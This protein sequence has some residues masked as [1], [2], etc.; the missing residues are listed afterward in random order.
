[1]MI[2]AD[3]AID[4]VT[5]SLHHKSSLLCTNIA[6]CRSFIA[7]VLIIVVNIVI[8]AIVIYL[9]VDKKCSIWSIGKKFIAGKLK[10]KWGMVSTIR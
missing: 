5:R 7:V 6:Y 10:D 8:I 2:L 9:I 1:M 4:D 3:G